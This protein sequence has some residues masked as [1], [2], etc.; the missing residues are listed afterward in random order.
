MSTINYDDFAA[1][2]ILVV[3]DNVENLKLLVSLLSG[4]GYKV[5]PASSGEL[6]LRS[7]QAKPP[8]LILLDVLMPDIDG[9][10]VC[11]R[12]KADEKTFPIPIIFIT[13]LDNEQDRVKGFLAGGVDYVS[14]P[15][16]KE[17]LLARIY[18]HSTLRLTILQLERTKARLK[19]V[20][21]QLET[22]ITERQKA[23]NRLEKPT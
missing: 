4:A 9:Y 7:V 1:L 22:E 15:I 3:D 2:D 8:T 11:R 19:E 18:V 16:C 6:A 17:E 21:I 5:R 12:L 20:N 10:E 13:M 14:K 23:E